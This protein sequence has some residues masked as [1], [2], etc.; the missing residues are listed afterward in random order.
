MKQSD[1]EKTSFTLHGKG[2]FHF[3]VM[4]VFWSHFTPAKFEQVME[5]M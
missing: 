1:K 2:L 4:F 3:K 5:Q